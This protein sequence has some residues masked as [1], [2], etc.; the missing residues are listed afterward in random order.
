MPPLREIRRNLWVR[1]LS[2]PL[3]TRALLIKGEERAAVW[4]C[5]TAP[6]VARPLAH[7]LDGMPHYLIYSHADWD[8]VWGAAAFT[9]GRLAVIGH[10]ECLRRFGDDAPRTLQRMQLAELGKWDDVRLVPPNLTFTSRLSLDLG[11]LTLEL[12]HCPG[13]TADCIIGWVPEWGIL[14]GGDAIETPLPVVNDARLLEGW[15][16]A[17]EA[18]RQEE[19]LERAI[20]S[21]GSLQGRESLDRTVAYL[22]ALTGDRQF[23]LPRT[24][25]DFYRETHQKNLIIAD[26]GLAR[27]E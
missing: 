10:A 21:H 13:H 20:P 3:Q 23:D 8:H 16:A 7:A 19:G 5:L 15:L 12:R 24:L 26:G 9:A 18:W 11:G 14:L 27:H 1:E 17:L 22:R 25:D 6:G 4:D 2:S